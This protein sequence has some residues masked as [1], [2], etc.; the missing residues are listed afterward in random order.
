MIKYKGEFHNINKEEINDFLDDSFYLSKLF[1]KSFVEYLG[2]NKELFDHLYNVDLVINNE[3]FD[4]DEGVAFYLP[5]EEE[6]S[7]NLHP[8]Y[9]EELME[10]SDSDN[11]KY[12]LSMTL[13]HEMIHI[14]R[15]IL[16]NNVVQCSDY[17]DTFDKEKPCIYLNKP[18]VVSDYIMDYNYEDLKHLDIDLII[19]K[20]LIQLPFEE[21]LTESMARVI[22]YY[23][24]NKNM[25][26]KTLIDYL[27]LKSKQDIIK[28][29]LELFKDKE[30]VKWFLLSCYEEVYFDYFKDR[31]KSNLEEIYKL[32]EYLY[33]ETSNFH[34]IKSKDKAINLELMLQKK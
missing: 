30:F 24:F 6:P 5:S 20:A 18:R 9:I 15:S 23:N 3:D 25:N 22:Y 10:S 11:N 21:C 29:T 12:N 16:I 14:N 32:Y 33:Y 2:L 28:I 7:I 26:Y 31:Y 4:F 17:L 13:L 19:D 27:K 1:F 8:I 34:K